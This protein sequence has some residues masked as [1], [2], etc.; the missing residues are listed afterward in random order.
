M[1]SYLPLYEDLSFACF[2]LLFGLLHHLAHFTLE[3]VLLFGLLL[4][5]LNL[6][7][8]L[9]LIQDVVLDGQHDENGDQVGNE[10]IQTQST[11]IVVEEE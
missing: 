1:D 2:L 5:L 4:V 6:C 10:V 3:P 11:R 7:M 8:D 9:V